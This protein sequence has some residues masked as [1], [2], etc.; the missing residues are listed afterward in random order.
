M[1]VALAAAAAT[2]GDA[3][4]VATAAVAALEASGVTNAG[5]AGGALTWDGCPEADACVVTPSSY[6]AVGAVAG[7]ASAVTAAAAPD[8]TA[9]PSGAGGT[10][11]EEVA[12]LVAPG[13]LAGDGAAAYADRLGLARAATGGVGARREDR[14]RRYSAVVAAAV[15]A[16][17]SRGGGG[18]GQKRPRCTFVGAEKGGRSDA[19]DGRAAA[20]ADV[21]PAARR[22]SPAA[23]ISPHHLSRRG[24]V[25]LGGGDCRRGHIG[26]TSGGA[27]SGAAGDS[28]P[29]PDHDAVTDTVGAVVVDACGGV[30]AAAS[31]GGAWLRPPGRLGAAAIPGAAAGVDPGGIAA[32]AASGVG[33][34]LIAGA[35]AATLARALGGGCPLAAAAATAMAQRPGGGHPS[36]PLPG[37]DGDNSRVGSDNSGS[38]RSSSDSNS[39]SSSSSCCCIGGGGGDRSRGSDGGG[40]DAATLC[41][42]AATSCGG[43]V[44]GVGPLTST[45]AAVSWAHATPS[46]AVGVWAPT[47]GASPAVTVSRL[48][49]GAA[50]AA[51][52]RFVRWPPEGEGG[53]R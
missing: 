5:P 9:A 15:D 35:V 16:E 2:V 1:R 40:F 25:T 14:W 7:L 21:H 44:L 28:S 49:P 22:T 3:A 18:G 47:G 23:L 6:G 37:S 34:R 48:P 33:E 41:R 29:P 46:F 27:A 45:G 43:G 38:S 11:G 17:R 51:G 50:V 8:G 53:A 20:S 32:A 31:S 13:V 42:V 52:G 10:A 12:G 39:S 24:T 19:N 26:R 30:A 4:A 36:D